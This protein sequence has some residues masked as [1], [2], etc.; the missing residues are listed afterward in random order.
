M[1]LHYDIRQYLR[2]SGMSPT[3]FGRQAVNDPRLV[4][5]LRNGRAAGPRIAARVYAFIAERDGR[6]GQCG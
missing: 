3:A 1:N 5:D 2:R 4:F 6:P